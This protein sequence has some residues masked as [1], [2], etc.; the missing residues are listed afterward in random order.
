MT[1]IKL[2]RTN[3]AASTAILT[4]GTAALVFGIALVLSACGG[5]PESRSVTADGLSETASAARDARDRTEA[6]DLAQG[7]LPRKDLA[8]AYVY[9][10]P[11]I[12][13]IDESLSLDGGTPV[14]LRVNQY[15]VWEVEPG[16]HLIE[17]WRGDRR[18][19]SR[20]LRLRPG[21][22]AF[23]KFAVKNNLGGNLYIVPAGDQEGRVFVRSANFGAQ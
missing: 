16:T 7:V 9:Q 15:R 10:E 18:L 17:A 14:P 12:P 21:Q 4:R 1:K 20:S 8:L 11:G 23:F 19:G 13:L 2:T 3:G 22:V 5:G 6:V